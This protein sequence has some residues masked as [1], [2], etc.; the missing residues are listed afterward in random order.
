MFYF[1]IYTITKEKIK[2]IGSQDEKLKLEL[3]KLIIEECEK[4]VDPQD[5]T[6][7]EILFSSDSKLEL[8]SMD[9]LQISMSLKKNYNIVV[10]DSK[11]LRKVMISINTLADFVQAK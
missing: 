4:E 9:A 11:K 1:S 10:T 6:D 7:E 3:K 2:M 8:D 5:I